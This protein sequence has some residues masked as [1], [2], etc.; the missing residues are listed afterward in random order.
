MHAIQDESIQMNLVNPEEVNVISDEAT[1]INPWPAVDDNDYNVEDED[2]VENACFSNDGVDHEPL[3]P[4][5]TSTA[6][7][8][9]TSKDIVDTHPK[10]SLVSKQHH[11]VKILLHDASIYITCAG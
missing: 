6:V 4:P 5:I 7:D 2:H 11:A 3:S 8:S 10:H 9:P 1:K